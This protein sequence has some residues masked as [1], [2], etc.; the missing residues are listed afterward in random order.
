LPF[1][2]PPVGTGNLAQVA[3]N[4]GVNLLQPGLYLGFAKIAIAVIDCPELAAIDRHKGFA[5]Q[6]QLAAKHHKFATDQAD[7]FTVVLTKVSDGLE[8]GSQPSQ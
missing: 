1:A 4:A 5:K 7:R 3:L 8:I 6:I 2:F